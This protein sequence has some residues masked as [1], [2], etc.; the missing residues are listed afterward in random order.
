MA[1]AL[2][3]RLLLSLISIHSFLASLSLAA[4]V[5]SADLP[6][7][8]DP[9]SAFTVV[10]RL[11][12][13][14]STGFTWLFTAMFGVFFVSSQIKVFAVKDS[15]DESEVSDGDCTFDSGCNAVHV[16]TS[17]ER[18]NVSSHSTGPDGKWSTEGNPLSNRP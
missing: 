8:Q 11:Q 13:A 3:P 5:G 9:E 17:C 18:S 14:L 16:L 6:P 10:I 4:R 1:V 2:Q 7:S 12:F 15:L